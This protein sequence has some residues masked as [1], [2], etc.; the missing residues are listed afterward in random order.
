MVV[1][2]TL[3]WN[4][5]TPKAL[6]F[7]EDTNLTAHAV[8]S[9]HKNMRNACKRGKAF[10]YCSEIMTQVRSATCQGPLSPH[11][12]PLLVTCCQ[13]MV[14]DQPHAMHHQ[15]SAICA[16]SQSEVCNAF[17]PE[18]ENWTHDLAGDGTMSE[19]WTS[20][21]AGR[22]VSEP[23]ESSRYRKQAHCR[24]QAS[25]EPQEPWT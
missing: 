8:I 25:P 5:G 2:G 16:L 17:C 21:H 9:S 11:I 13:P 6:L 1:S 14:L 19:P 24:R 20:D 18:A 10:I 22:A 15:H 4:D 7:L 23:K 3:S 12:C